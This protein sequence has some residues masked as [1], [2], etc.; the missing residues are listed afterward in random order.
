VDYDY[1]PTYDFSR[2]KTYGWM[3]GPADDALEGIAEKRVQYAL[4]NQLKAKGYTPS[5]EAPDFLILLQATVKT[6]T[7]G[8]VG[9]GMSVGIP[10]GKG[11]VTVGGGKSKEQVNQ[12]GTL[13][14]DFLDGTSRA[15]L[16]KATIAGAIKENASPEDLQ[17]RA[18]QV[19]AERLKTFPPPTGR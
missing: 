4:D 3:P 9:G 15:L 11:Y 16:W 19:A 13:V 7:G 18:N 5:A 1:D 8:R 6:T 2:L 17:E 12:E 14:V 10:V